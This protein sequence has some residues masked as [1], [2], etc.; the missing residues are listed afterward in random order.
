MSNTGG[1]IIPDQ[2]NPKNRI[3]TK[4]SWDDPQGGTITAWVDSETREVLSVMGSVNKPYKAK[5]EEEISRITGEPVFSSDSDPFYDSDF[6]SD[7][8]AACIE[9][10][11]H[12]KPSG[13]TQ[14]QFICR[15]YGI[16]NG[17]P[18]LSVSTFKKDLKKAHSKGLIDMDHETKRFIPKK[19]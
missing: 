3:K 6:I 14:Y 13:E 9:Y 2:E 10:V 8:M 7:R 5:W 11:E 4:I 19:K 1:A 12:A 18:N 17:I 15:T 16:N